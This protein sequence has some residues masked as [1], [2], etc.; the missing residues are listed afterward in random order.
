MEYKFAAILNATTMHKEDC[1]NL[2]PEQIMAIDCIRILDKE[3]FFFFST[4]CS[5]VCS[6]RLLAAATASKKMAVYWPPTI[7][8]SPR[9]YTL[10]ESKRTTTTSLCCCLR[11]LGR[12]YHL[13]RKLVTLT[14]FGNPTQAIRPFLRGFFATAAKALWC[15]WVKKVYYWSV[16]FLWRASGAITTTVSLSNLRI[17]E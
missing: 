12:L 3:I 10:Y 14:F 15:I 1:P 8:L 4:G 5:G 13:W 6:S 2:D 9:S 16:L 7:W 17:Y 11:R